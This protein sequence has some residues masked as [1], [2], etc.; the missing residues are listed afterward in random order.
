MKRH[1]R[2]I[3]SLTLSAFKVLK[4]VRADKVKTEQR[5]TE[6]NENGEQGIERLFPMVA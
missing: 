3:K 4:R 2:Y 1:D 5:Q 6:R